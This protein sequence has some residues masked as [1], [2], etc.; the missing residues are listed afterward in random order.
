MTNSI[1]GT[2]FLNDQEAVTSVKIKKSATN[3][4]RMRKK[5]NFF[6]DK[7]SKEGTGIIWASNP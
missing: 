1:L 5:H 7:M 4:D 2:A 6:Y 3:C